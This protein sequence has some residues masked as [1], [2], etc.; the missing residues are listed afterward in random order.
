MNGEARLLARCLGCQSSRSI[1]SFTDACLC[2]TWRRLMVDEVKHCMLDHDG[3]LAHSLRRLLCARREALPLGAAEQSIAEKMG[4]IARY[5]SLTQ[6]PR[7]TDPA[8]GPVF[9]EIM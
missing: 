6:R 3:G 4:S 1:E 2:T 7:T 9:K 8:S 5:W